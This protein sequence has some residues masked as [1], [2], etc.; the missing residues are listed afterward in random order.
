MR[1][2]RAWLADQGVSVLVLEGNHDV[3]FAP[4]IKRR[5]HTSIP[6]PRTCTVA[7]W[8]IAHGHQ[9]FDGAQKISGHHHPVFRWQGIAAPCFL[10]GPGRIV[11]PAFSSNAAGCDVLSAA[12]PRE[13]SAVPFRCLVSTG[14]EVLDFGPLAALRHRATPSH[15]I[16]SPAEHDTQP[17]PPFW[18]PWALRR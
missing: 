9:P 12:A 8:T 2:L 15:L 18:L 3:G 6:L 4:S 13:W 14:C 10:V 17:F 16:K 11:L 1:K 7:G 5:S